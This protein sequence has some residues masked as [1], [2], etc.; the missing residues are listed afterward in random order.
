MLVWTDTTCQW[1]PCF[2]R[3]ETYYQNDSEPGSV[4]ETEVLVTAHTAFRD[5]PPKSL[6]NTEISSRRKR[7]APPFHYFLLLRCSNTLF[8]MGIHFQGP[9]SYTE[10][11]K[12]VDTCKSQTSLDFS[13]AIKILT[14]LYL[15]TLGW[16]LIMHFPRQVNSECRN[17]LH[18]CS[19]ILPT[20]QWLIGLWRL[21]R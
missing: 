13:L 20:V 8:I 17:T 1:P 18:S 7:Q 14:I 9:M 12:Y 16:I 10:T 21:A 19:I 3:K 5:W 15:E 11:Y 6:Q 4:L 2:G